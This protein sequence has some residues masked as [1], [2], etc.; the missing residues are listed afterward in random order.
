MLWEIVEPYSLKALCVVTSLVICV[1]LIFPGWFACA[2]LSNL[3]N[4]PVAVQLNEISVLGIPAFVSFVVCLFL[5]IKFFGAKEAI[6]PS[7][8]NLSEKNNF[9][10]TYELE[11]ECCNMISLKLQLAITFGALVV[12][13]FLWGFV[14]GDLLGLGR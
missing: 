2:G 7:K 8:T 9:K 6:W 13:I 4:S 3:C 1:V 5:P 12:G 10:T 11:N 14:F